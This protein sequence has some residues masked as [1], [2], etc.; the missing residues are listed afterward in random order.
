M[1]IRW[2]EKRTNF[3]AWLISH[4]WT[5]Y[6]IIKGKIFLLWLWLIHLS[7][8]N[9]KCCTMRT[10]R[11]PVITRITIVQVP[12][13]CNLLDLVWNDIHLRRYIS[14]HSELSMLEFTTAENY[15]GDGPKRPKPMDN[16]SVGQISVANLFKIAVQT[17]IWQIATTERPITI[18]W[19]CTT[20]LCFHVWTSFNLSGHLPRVGKDSELWWVSIIF[21][22]VRSH[23]LAI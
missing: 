5:L 16:A 20:M 23:S 22:I 7:I 4:D 19:T 3:P 8:C 10:G 14:N 9:A 11:P 13:G 17:K 15:E 21:L 2:G 18:Y 1:N 12:K 6:L